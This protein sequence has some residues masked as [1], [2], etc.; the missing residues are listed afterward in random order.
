MAIVVDGAIGESMQ[1]ETPSVAPRY[2]CPW[3]E[4]AFVPAGS[5][6][7]SIPLAQGTDR[8]REDD[9][10]NTGLHTGR[11]RAP[12]RERKVCELRSICVRAPLPMMPRNR[13]TAGL[14][15]RHG[16]VRCCSGV[17]EFK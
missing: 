12:P 14:R 13:P 1:P 17:L 3:R 7:P 4:R 15:I 10:M 6:K 16:S 11:S 5:A 9:G 2:R 8:T